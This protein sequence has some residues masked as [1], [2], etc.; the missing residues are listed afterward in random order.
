[1]WWSGRRAGVGAQRGS[2]SLEFLGVVTLAAVLVAGTV[3]A[4]VA[5]DPAI[6]D[7][8]W[9]RICQIMGGDCAASDA[10][11]NQ[12]FKPHDCDVATSRDSVDATVDVAFV[13][14]EGGG[15]VQ[16][17]TKSNGDIEIT[18]AGEGRVGVVGSVGG[19]GELELGGTKIGASAEAEAAA[20]GGASGGETFV[21]RDP[22]K[23]D[24]FESYVKR[25]FGEDVAGT[26]SPVFR[27]LNWA[28]EGITNEEPPANDGV[29]KWFVQADAAAEAQASGSVGYGTSAG[30]DASAMRSLGTE[31]DRGDPDDATDDTRT[32]YY[33]LNW[34]AG[35]SVTLPAVKGFEGSAERTGTIKVTYD[36]HREPVKMQLVD[37]STGSFEVGLTATGSR[38]GGGGSAQPVDPRAAE[39]I[40]GLRNAG[41]RFM[42]GAHNHSVVV[43]QTLDLTD[44]TARAAFDDWYNL[45]NGAVTADLQTAPG[46]ESEKGETVVGL[47][48]DSAARF[49]DVLSQ[50][51]RT[52]IVEYDGETTGLGV[53]A[54]LGLGLK[55]GLDVGGDRAS[56]QAVQAQ[57][58]GAPTDDGSR[59]LFPLD[60]CAS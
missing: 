29:Q 53:A 55:L 9:A 36:R 50:Q 17:V 45:A 28:Y 46:L 25:E 18:V 8:I 7:T 22:D 20:T 40:P 26:F 16:R 10:P 57:Y 5:S 59:P 43:T 12:A 39:D 15:S 23:A 35:A 52:S 21:F 51:A 11:S 56:M 6:R 41:I 34:D 33:E 19:R 13:R 60:D 37:R 48:P 31:F 2:G 38:N 44:P 4:V 24:E 30:A 32:V 54:E 49:A 47:D 42:A 3:G 27:G 58:L 14:L 1:M